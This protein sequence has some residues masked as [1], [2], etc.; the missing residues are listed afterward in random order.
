MKTIDHVSLRTLDIVRLVAATASFSETARQLGLQRAIVAQCVA[1]LEA[2][3]DT[4]L[5]QRT[6][7]VVALT[8]EGEALIARIGGAVETIREGLLGTQAQSGTT[9]GSVTL[10]CSH[11]FGRVFVA[12]ALARFAKAQPDITVDF[13]MADRLDDL[14]VDRIDLAIRLGVLPD[15]NLFARKLGALEVILVAA[16]TLLGTKG[17]PRTIDA[18]STLPAIGFRVRGSGEIYA[19]A[20]ESKSE[21]VSV[22]SQRTPMICNSIEGVVALALEGVGAAAVPRYLVREALA[23][24]AL[25][26]LL[27]AYKLDPIPA[28]VVFTSR[29]LMPK[30]V[31]VLADHLVKEISAAV[32]T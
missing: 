20:L 31:R 30:R 26:A 23:S 24:G 11:A 14:I 19:W 12:P 22:N 15:S 28:H 21:R 13:Y 7:R 10:S 29:E 17:A 3:L 18:L 16:P 6:T 2:Q 25:K 8:E 27:P 1:Q 32:A 9:A 5:F 4:K